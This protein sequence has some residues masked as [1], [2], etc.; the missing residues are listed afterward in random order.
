MQ[1]LVGLMVI[2]VGLIRNHFD[3][4]IGEGL[5][6]FDIRTDHRIRLNVPVKYPELYTDGKKMEF[7]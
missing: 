7:S 3:P 1:S 5:K 6:P 4:L 2:D